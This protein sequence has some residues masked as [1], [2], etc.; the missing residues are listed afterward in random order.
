M[1]LEIQDAIVYIFVW[2][3]N[4]FKENYKFKKLKYKSI[5]LRLK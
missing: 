2:K 4:E 5:Y 3:L 1:K